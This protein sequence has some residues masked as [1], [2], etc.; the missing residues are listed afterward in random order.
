MSRCVC[1]GPDRQRACMVGL[2]QKEFHMTASYK[3]VGKVKE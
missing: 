2:Q 3:V 1:Q